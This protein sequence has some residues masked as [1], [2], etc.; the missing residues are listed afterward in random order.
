MPVRAKDR[1]TKQRRKKKRKIRV[2]LKQAPFGLA[3]DP[4]R[5]PVVQPASLPLGS[6]AT[7]VAISSLLCSE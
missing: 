1:T 2:A 7:L 4:D 5:G 3:L 6:P